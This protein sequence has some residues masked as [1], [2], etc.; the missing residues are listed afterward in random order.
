MDEDWRERYLNS[1]TSRLIAAYEPTGSAACI[2]EWVRK[3]GYSVSIASPCRAARHRRSGIE[4]DGSIATA[5][6]VAHRQIG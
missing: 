4:P 2:L 5:M 3:H 1:T 6:V